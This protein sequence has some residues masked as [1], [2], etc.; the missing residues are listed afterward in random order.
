MTSKWPH[1][2]AKWYSCVPSSGLQP[3]LALTLGPQRQ[4]PIYPRRGFPTWREWDSV[5]VLRDCLK[6]TE[7]ARFIP[8]YAQSADPGPEYFTAFQTNLRRSCK[9]S[10][11]GSFQADNPMCFWLL[12][13]Q[14]TPMRL[15]G[16][17]L[18]ETTNTFVQA[19]GPAIVTKRSP[20][21]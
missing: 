20:R 21:S 1:L 8:V 17:R 13:G 14:G 15:R 4:E 11:G 3:D 5:R 7:W 19:G 18:S 16:W 6:F 2:E 9:L 10:G 12:L